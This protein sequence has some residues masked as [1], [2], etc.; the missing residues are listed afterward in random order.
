M[1]K[2]AVLLIVLCMLICAA[3]AE[4]GTEADVRPLP[5][6]PERTDLTD[7]AFDVQVLDMDRAA[8][9]QELT[10]MLYVTDRYDADQIRNLSP[11]ETILIAGTVYT[12]EAVDIRDESWTDEDNDLLYEVIPV[13]EEWEGLWFTEALDGTF[14]AHV[15]DWNP[16]TYVDTVTVKLPL[17]DSFVYY[18]YPGGEE[19][20][21]GTEEDLL[22]DLAE[23]SPEFF[24][25]Y[26]T[27][28]I[29]QDGTLAEFHN[30]SYPW[31]PA[32]D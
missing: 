23:S 10:L 31:G 14:I 2:L 6:G 13:E 18:D 9:K 17:P 11:G 19:P 15:G 30:W 24:S 4:D 8:E 7:G 21:E 16:V 20:R 29:F 32:A 26:N 28:V 27:Y 12:V 22:G 1:K 25:P 3:A 5:V